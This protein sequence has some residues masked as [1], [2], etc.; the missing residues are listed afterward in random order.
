MKR[1]W[2]RILVAIA[3]VVPAIACA[4]GQLNMLCSVQPPWCV[5]T[6]MTRS[7]T[8]TRCSVCPGPSCRDSITSINRPGRARPHWA[9]PF[10]RSNHSE[11][12]SNISVTAIAVN[13][14]ITS[15]S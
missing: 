13:C 6:A 4:Q 9:S 1:R 14:R 5:A 3:A 15:I 8:R 11:P 10:R 2:T 7:A 12:A